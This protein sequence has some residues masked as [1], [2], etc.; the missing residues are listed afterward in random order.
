MPIT[1]M[2]QQECSLNALIGQPW[3]TSLSLQLWVE[4]SPLELLGVRRVAPGEM[5]VLPE[6]GG[7]DTGLVTTGEVELET[8]RLPFLLI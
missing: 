7:M 2:Q 8:H 6:E 3:V 1:E 5:E 4:S